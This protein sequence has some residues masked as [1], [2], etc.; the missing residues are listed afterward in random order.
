MAPPTLGSLYPR[1]TKHSDAEPRGLPIGLFHNLLKA[2]ITGAISVDAW[3]LFAAV[4]EAGDGIVRDAL[5]AS[6]VVFLMLMLMPK[7]KK[8]KKMKM[9]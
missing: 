2:T 8:K 4:E 9:P 7:V 5:P 3:P 6:F 1:L